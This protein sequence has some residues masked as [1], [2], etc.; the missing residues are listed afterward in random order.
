MIRDGERV[1]VGWS[2]SMFT[3]DLLMLLILSVKVVMEELVVTNPSC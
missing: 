2:C 1:E 3:W